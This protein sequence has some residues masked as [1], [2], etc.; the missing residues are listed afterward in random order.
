[1][2][3][4]K[5]KTWIRQESC[6]EVFHRLGVWTISHALDPNPQSAN[7]PIMYGHEFIDLDIPLP[8]ILRQLA[9][10]A[11]VID[12]P[13]REVAYWNRFVRRAA[14]AV[15]RKRPVHIVPG[16]PLP[17]G[18]LHHAELTPEPGCLPFS[19]L[20]AALDRLA[21]DF[22]IPEEV[23][24]FVY[25]GIHVGDAD[26]LARIIRIKPGEAGAVADALDRWRDSALAHLRAASP[27]EVDYAP[28]VPDWMRGKPLSRPILAKFI[29]RTRKTLRVWDRTE[30][31][32]FGLSWVPGTRI[33]GN[34]VQYDVGANWA[35]IDAIMSR[36]GRKRERW[37]EALKR[38]VECYMA[39][40]NPVVDEVVAREKNAQRRAS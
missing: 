39:G 40:E 35:T 6:I 24:H 11:A 15:G 28:D 13:D 19:D 34:V 8:A 4:A 12:L 33:G 16:D 31:G 14:F 20:Y 2:T 10:G 32:P 30:E 21:G 1:M 23:M 7:G 5:K 3:R 38:E 9:G 29:G 26:I 25:N 18:A 22:R 37:E 27:A 36:A 17:S